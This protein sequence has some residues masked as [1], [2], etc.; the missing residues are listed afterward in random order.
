MP[1]RRAATHMTDDYLHDVSDAVR[2]LGAGGARLCF[3]TVWERDG[4]KVAVFPVSSDD[5]AEDEHAPDE[6][7]FAAA[8]TIIEDVRLLR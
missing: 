2:R 1:R 8:E 3:E 4:P 5:P 6:H 7:L